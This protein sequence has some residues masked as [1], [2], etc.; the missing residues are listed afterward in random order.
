MSH[1]VR[2]AAKLA[3]LLLLISPIPGF[4]A[5]AALV[6]VT[7]DAIE[8]APTG[9]PATDHLVTVEQVLQGSVPGTSLIVRVPREERAPEL[10]AGERV[11]LSLIP[12]NDGSFRIRRVE[13]AG[14]EPAAAGPVDQALPVTVALTLPFQT[15]Q[16]GEAV[17]FQAGFTGPAR[18]A[19]WEIG[20]GALA[21]SDGPC[22]AETF[23]AHHIFTRPGSY[24]IRVTATSPQG[25]IA[26]TTRTVFVEGDEVRLAGRE[27]LLQNVLSAPGGVQSDL[28]LYNAGEVPVLVRATFVP[29]GAFAGVREVTIS[30]GTSV[31]L[32]DVVTGLFGQRDQQGSLSLSYLLPRSS[33]DA[34]PLVFAYSRSAVAS[35]DSAGPSFG[36][37]IPEEPESGWSAAERI[38]P[39]ILEGNGFVST[40]SAVNLEGVRGQVTVTL[41]DQDGEPVG[42]P[43]VLTLGPRNL[44]LQALSRMFPA[45]VGHRGPFTAHFT[46]NG[47]SF[48]ASTTLLEIESQDQIFIPAAP[49]DA[50]SPGGA[51]GT[52]TTTGDL[53]FPRV[54]RGPGQFDTFQTSRLAAFNPAG[55]GRLL[56]VEFWERGHDNLAPRTAYRYVEPGRSLLVNDILLDLFGVEAGI[57]ALRVTWSGPAGPAPRVLSVM[58]SGTAGTAGGLTGSQGKRFGT[59]V[60]AVTAASAVRSRGVDFGAEQSPVSRSSFG[61][62][63]LASASTTLRLTLRDAAGH[64]LAGTRVGLEPRQH[65]ERNVAG[66]FPGIGNGRSWAIETEVVS[67]GPVFTYLAQINA[68]GDLDYTFGH[69]K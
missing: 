3:L 37:L 23:C 18:S 14:Q 67:G 52:A 21:F 45:V 48:T 25:Q 20:A 43:A 1:A 47:I 63:N 22:A 58:V 9:G 60:D 55:Q 57:G 12:G 10:R 59:L 26:E 34:K 6:E 32:P 29:R 41:R 40:L 16:T 11:R 44:R 33:S 64:V 7:I 30:P 27:S 24:R 56:T 38:A 61:A 51:E 54:V 49:V 31:F 62:V 17:L 19:R 35:A 46:S 36:Q 8:T 69:P 42:E 39:G 13:R 4:A 50:D 2:P 15:L 5:Q 65:L 53:F 68:A 66:L 28:Q